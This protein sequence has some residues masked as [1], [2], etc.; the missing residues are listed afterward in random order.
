MIREWLESDGR[1]AQYDTATQYIQYLNAS[2]V[3]VEAPRE[4]TSDEVERYNTIFPMAAAEYAAELAS[5]NATLFG[6]LQAVRAV[7]EDN[8]VTTQELQQNIPIVF[9][10]L[11][12]YS[13]F[14]PS[15]MTHHKLASLLLAQSVYS[16]Q[17]LLSNAGSG[18]SAAITQ[19]TAIRQDLD[20]LRDE[21]DSHVAN[22]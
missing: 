1:I 10:A 3:N 4:A 16:I 19:S 5:L 18:V 14:M 9:N 8:A 21:F 6:A 22:S 12:Q 20:A 17:L 13:D 15:E 11:K 2:R 7:N